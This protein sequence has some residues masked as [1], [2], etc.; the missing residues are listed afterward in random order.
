[1]NLFYL[2]LI[3]KPKNECLKFNKTQQ[4]CLDFDLL[5]TMSRA[6]DDLS[7]TLKKI[8]PIFFFFLNFGNIPFPCTAVLLNYKKKKMRVFLIQSGMG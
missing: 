8:Y 3:F 7:P 2:F 1:M 5:F 6:K 4:K